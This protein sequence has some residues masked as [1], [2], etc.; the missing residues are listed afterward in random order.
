MA[1]E[2][3]LVYIKYRDHVLYHRALPRNLKPPVR[4]CVGWLVYAGEDYITICW[5][6]DVDPPTLKGG[7]PQASGL[8]LLR[9]DILELRRLG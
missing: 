7:D 2:T 1:K 6:R 5:D 4:E 8:V 3:P 9:S